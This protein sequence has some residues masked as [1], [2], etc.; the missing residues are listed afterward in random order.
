V[1]SQNPKFKD[2]LSKLSAYKPAEPFLKKL[3]EEYGHMFNGW[4]N[5]DGCYWPPRFPTIA[6]SQDLRI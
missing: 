2:I 4:F 5:D 3:L 6:D 1:D